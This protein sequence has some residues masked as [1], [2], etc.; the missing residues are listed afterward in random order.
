MFV[1]PSASTDS[2]V[3]PTVAALAAFSATVLVPVLESVGVVASTSSTSVRVIVT[4]PTSEAPLLS[5]A[6]SVRVQELVSS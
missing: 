4:V 3:T 2:T 6:R 1:V 5:E